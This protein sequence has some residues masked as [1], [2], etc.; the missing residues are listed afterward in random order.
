MF[1]WLFSILQDYSDM[2]SFLRVGRY[3]SFR[4]IAAMVTASF[5]SLW[6][7]PRFIEY[8]QLK[9][10]GQIIRNDGPEAHF[11]KAG[12]PTMGGILLLVVMTISTLLWMDFQN[13]YV[14]ASLAITISYG[15]VGFFDDYLK[16]SKK[17]TKGLAG[18]YKLFWQFT[19]SALVMSLLCIY[20]T[21][22]EPGIY[23]PFVSPDRFYIPLPLW[24]FIPFSM[25]VVT[26]TSNA[27]NLTDGLDGLAIGPV[28]IASGTFM[29]LAYSAGT[30]L[31]LPSDTGILFKFNLANYL[32]LPYVPEASEL[33]VFAAALIGAGLGFLWYNAYPAQVFM[34]DVGALALGGALGMMAVLTRNELLSVIICGLFVVEA[35][36]VILQ[37][38]SY[39]L[40]QKRIFKMAPIHHHFEKI[41]W[42]EP[43][44][45]VRFWM[46]SFLLSL[47]ALISLKLR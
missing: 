17:N 30:V 15:L 31:H 1:V 45:V 40:R 10:F 3:V 25:L 22:F 23:L 32:N 28:M 7:Y 24:L 16:I 41:G 27:V 8:L 5:L 14:W 9:H 38:T 19:I 35:L 47:V 29:I 12:T 6:L 4:V 26:G 18:R 36:S 39:K 37:T 13:I 46:I 33:A 44:I 2:L 11:K 43:K 21:G 34:G 20:K 42:T